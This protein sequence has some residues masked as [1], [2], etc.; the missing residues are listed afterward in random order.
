LLSGL[1]DW[2]GPTTTHLLLAGRLAL[3][4]GHEAGKHTV[5]NPP[6]TDQRGCLR[7]VNYGH[8]GNIYCD[9]GAVEMLPAQVYLP[10]IVRNYSG[11]PT[12]GVPERACF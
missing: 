8:D 7:P 6:T 1:G 5:L 12:G 4:N 10:V 2:D 11:Q 9:I 3:E